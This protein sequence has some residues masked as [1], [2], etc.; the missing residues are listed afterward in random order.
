VYADTISTMSAAS[1]TR[2][3]VCDVNLATRS[4]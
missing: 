2:S 3:T 4:G 1:L